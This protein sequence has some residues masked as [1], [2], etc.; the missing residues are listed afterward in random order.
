MDL[1][2]KIKYFNQIFTTLLNKIPTTSWSTNEVLIEFYT[3]TIPIT[4]TMFV[5]RMGN[6]TLKETLDESIQVEIEMLIL[7]GNQSSNK[8]ETQFPTKK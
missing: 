2:E 1:K 3:S 7:N 5:K 4:I 6:P 8:M